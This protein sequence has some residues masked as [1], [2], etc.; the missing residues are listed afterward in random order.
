MFEKKAGLIRIADSAVGEVE[1]LDDGVSSLHQQLLS[2]G[3]NSSLTRRN[4]SSWDGKG[5]VKDNKSPWIAPTKVT[6]SSTP[7]LPSLTQNMY[8][9]TRGKHSHL[10]PYPLPANI[11]STPAFR[12]LHWSSPPAHVQTRTCH[13]KDG[14]PS[15]LQVIAFSE[16]GVEVQ[17]LDLSAIT[18]RKGKGREPI[19]AQSDVGGCGTGF[20]VVGGHWD[21]QA[22]ADLSPTIYEE[23]DTDTLSE[24]SS[25]ELA[26]V[27]HAQEGIYAWM[28]KDAADWRIVWL[29]N[30][31]SERRCDL[32]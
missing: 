27:L 16:D 15:F 18:E 21:K 8:I 30:Q 4:R 23:S 11:A 9:L 24:M 25:E 20:L 3:G 14:S 29:G 26:G 19:R 6:L 12:V 7:G 31:E 22:A 10:L 2:P 28:R 17:E 32:G 1:L 5:F 13:P